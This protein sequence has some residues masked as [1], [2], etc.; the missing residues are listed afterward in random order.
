MYSLTADKATSDSTPDATDFVFT[1]SLT[2]ITFM[3]KFALSLILL[4]PVIFLQAQV[5]EDKIEYN[6]EKQACLVMEYNFPPQAVEN[7][8]IAKMN[9][10]GYKG[11]EEKGMF[12]KDKGF[13]VYKEAM[14]GDISPSRYD[15]VVNIDRKSRK[16]SDAAVLYLIV[17][18]DDAN[19]LSRMNT[20]ELGKA[21]AFLYNLLPDI[22]EAN[23]E[24]QITAQED[25][26][27]KAEKKLK[28]LQSDKD[29][30]EKKIKKLQDDIKDNEKNQEQQVAEIENQRKALDA[31]KGKRKKSA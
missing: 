18:K 12:N 30:M 27:V 2:K 22:E 13:R 11:K 25:V 10:L 23:L 28:N 24:L 29:D 16:E 19:A 5:T 15:Y 9:K 17:M 26:V 4:S 14:I 7:A 8:V 3:R 20:E 21:K 31:L 6:K 1:V